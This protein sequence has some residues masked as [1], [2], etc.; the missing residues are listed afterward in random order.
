MVAEDLFSCSMM[1][2]DLVKKNNLDGFTSSFARLLW[3]LTAICHDLVAWLKLDDLLLK[4]NWNKLSA[5][6]ALL[7][8]QNFR[9]VIY[10]DISGFILDSF[11]LRNYFVM[12]QNLADS[13]CV[14]IFQL[15]SSRWL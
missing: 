1:Q 7:S 9:A 3:I 15:S 2:Q 13:L 12:I 11:S 10:R 8:I 5:C 6:V 4:I 14:I